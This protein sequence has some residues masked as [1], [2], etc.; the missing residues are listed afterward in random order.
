MS[1]RPPRSLSDRPS[2][3]LNPL[4]Y[5]LASERADALG[6]QGRKVEAALAK[7]A[8]SSE[9][10]HRIADRESL[11]EEASEAVWALFIQREVCGLRNNRDVIARY[12]IPGEV[13]ARI[14]AIRR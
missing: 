3:A 2:T 12:G 14:G 5:E 13:L 6:R 4:E 10:D 1:F 7:L 11:L 8:A 9:N